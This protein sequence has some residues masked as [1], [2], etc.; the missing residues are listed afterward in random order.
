MDDPVLLTTP[1]GVPLFA[2]FQKGIT[3]YARPVVAGVNVQLAATPGGAAIAATADGE[4]TM[5]GDPRYFWANPIS[6]W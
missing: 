5:I 2:P 3:Y 6:A 1:I 4:A